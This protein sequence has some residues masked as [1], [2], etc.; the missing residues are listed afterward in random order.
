LL[1]WK[2]Q[3]DL[4]KNAK[5]DSRVF[6]GPKVGKSVYF[7]QFFSGQTK[8][9]SVQITRVNTVFHWVTH[10]LHFNILGVELKKLLTVNMLEK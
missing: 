1:Y 4:L 8:K 10:D 9:K 5:R 7:S 6:P 3:K 2:K